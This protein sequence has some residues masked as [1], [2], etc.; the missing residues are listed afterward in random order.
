[1]NKREPRLSQTDYVNR[2]GAQ[3]PWCESGNLEGHDRDFG[4]GMAT[5][6]VGCLDCEQFWIEEY[7]LTGY[8]E[9]M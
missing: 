2:E 9:V 7:Q 4:R 5:L 3:C 1:M 8:R 6:E